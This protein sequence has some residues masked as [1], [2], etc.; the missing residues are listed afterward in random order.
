MILFVGNSVHITK[1]CNQ[2]SGYTYQS[3]YMVENSNVWK[4]HLQSNIVEGGSMNVEIY[5]VQLT[6]IAKII[7]HLIRNLHQ[8]DQLLSFD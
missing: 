6:E 1:M 2:P 8:R 4:S 7:Y 5:L 3:I